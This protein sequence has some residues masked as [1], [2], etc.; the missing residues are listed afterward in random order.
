MKMKQVCQLTGLTERTIRFYVEK[1]LCAPETRWMDQ[2]KYYDFSKENVEELRQA[3]ELRKAY[4]S[5]QA[6]QTMRSSP[7]RIP[8]ILKTYRQGLAAD[9]AHKRKLL[10]VMEQMDVEQIGSV[11][12]LAN[13]LERVSAALSLPQADLA[14]EFGRLDG[15]SREEKEEAY[16]EYQRR[17]KRDEKIG[18]FVVFGIAGLNAAGSLA[19][20]IVRADF[21]YLFTFLVQAGFS[22]ALCC[23]VRWVRWLFVAG[24]VIGA[25]STF[26]LLIQA[27]DIGG[28]PGL[29]FCIWYFCAFSLCADRDIT[30]MVPSGEG[31][32]LS[33]EKW[34]SAFCFEGAGALVRR[35]RELYTSSASPSNPERLKEPGSEF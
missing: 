16:Q 11:A 5:I 32:F 15:L 7:E 30:G 31:V 26:L 14:P 4:F 24:G 33:E 9:E 20:W 22:I 13:K 25:A 8:E 2:R 35:K 10:D 27:A 12:A 6:I 17:R 3:A 34:L 28:M 23:G 18:K 19:S 21:T 29:V 1:E